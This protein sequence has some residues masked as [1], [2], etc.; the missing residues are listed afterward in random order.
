LFFSANSGFNALAERHALLR[1]NQQ[2]Y[3]AVAL[4]SWV[5]WTM[6][7]FFVEPALPAPR[8]TSQ[9]LVT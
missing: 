8:T 6:D 7:F 1:N 4:C 3:H 9:L 5:K 2:L